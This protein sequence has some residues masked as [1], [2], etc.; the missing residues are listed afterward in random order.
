[1][2]TIFLCC[3]ILQYKLVGFINNFITNLSKFYYFYILQKIDCFETLKLFI[4]LLFLK[5]IITIDL[6]YMIMPTWKNNDSHTYIPN[7][8][9]TIVSRNNFITSISSII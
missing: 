6:Y 1:M 7:K 5:I 8:C 3:I 9:E 4:F 2:D